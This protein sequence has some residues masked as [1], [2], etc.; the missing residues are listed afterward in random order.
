[1]RVAEALRAVGADPTRAELLIEH[2]R[3]VWRSADR[4]GLVSDRSLGRILSRHTLDSLGFASAR[5]PGPGERWADV[6]SGAG[7]PG[8]VLAVAF[9]ETDFVLVESQQRRAGFLELQ[10]LDLG[11]SNARVFAR[12]LQELPEDQ[13]GF[14]VVTARAFSSSEGS[15]SSP[16]AFGLL[17]TIAKPPHGVVLIAAGETAE[18]PD[19]DSATREVRVLPPAVD[20]PTRYLMM[21]V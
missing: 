2:A 13:S 14:D 11:A 7:F 18:T 21:H 9:P 20:Y 3:A 4:L 10:L 15:G 8:L 12:R 19:P 17:S 1:M 5:R 6:G 16:A